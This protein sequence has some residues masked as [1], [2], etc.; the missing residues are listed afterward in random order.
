M[1]SDYKLEQNFPNPFNPTTTIYYSLPKASNVSIKVYDML[2]NEVAIVINEFKPEGRYSAL[3]DASNLASGVYFYTMKA[4][5]FTDTR[6][7]ILIK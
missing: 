2:G 1:P 6:K 7:M 4:S 5:E 3:F